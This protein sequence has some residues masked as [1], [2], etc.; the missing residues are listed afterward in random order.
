L[1]S[2]ELVAGLL[3]FAADNPQLNIVGEGPTGPSGRPS[4]S[5]PRRATLALYQRALPY[6]SLHSAHCHSGES[7]NS[8]L[9]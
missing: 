2:D 6:L 9:P 5:L 8:D 4:G 3:F 7:G 1:L